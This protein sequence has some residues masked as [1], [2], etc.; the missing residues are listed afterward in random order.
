MAFRGAVAGC[1]LCCPFRGSLL[2]GRYPH[3]CVPGHEYRMPPEQ[4]T[5]AH[6]FGEAGY[7]AAYFGK[8]HLDGWHER[9]GRAALHVVPP[10][11]RGGF[12]EWVGYE[13]NN[14]QWDCWVHGGDGAD[15]RPYRLP[16]Y[17]TDC[18]TDLRRYGPA[19]DR[20]DISRCR[21]RRRTG[22]AKPTRF[23]KW[24]RWRN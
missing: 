22:P 10:E 14:S 18:L 1:P 16:G 11:R 19:A 13:N 7:H 4:P 8:W 20:L 6:A 15:D 5:V 12:D 9:D 21:A 23:F 24:Q 17:E 3:E 2:T